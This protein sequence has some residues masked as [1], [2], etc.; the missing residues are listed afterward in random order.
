MSPFSH[1]AVRI[2]IGLV[3]FLLVTVQIPNTETFKGKKGWQTLSENEPTKNYVMVP[4]YEQNN[5]KQ[6]VLGAKFVEL[7]ADKRQVVDWYPN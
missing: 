2:T 7:E 6:I 5:H 3:L 1:V 4:K